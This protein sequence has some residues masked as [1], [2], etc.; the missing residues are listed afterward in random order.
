MLTILF[1]HDDDLE[2]IITE[3]K[4]FE[5]IIIVTYKEIVI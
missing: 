1:L 3:H 2:V 4:Y 5:I